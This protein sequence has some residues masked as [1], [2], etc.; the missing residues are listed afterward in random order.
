MNPRHVLKG[1]SGP[2][3]RGLLAAAVLGLSAL[4]TGQV[5]T[6]VL[7]QSIAGAAPGEPTMTMEVGGRTWA[8]TRFVVSTITMSNQPVLSMTGLLDGPKISKLGFLV[9]L[10]SSGDYIHS[11]ELKPMQ[12][13]MK[14]KDTPSPSVGSFNVDLLGSNSLESLFSF[15]SGAIV[16]Q[17]YDAAAKS[18]SGSF[19]GIMMSESG[20]TLEAKNGV[21][22]NVPI[23]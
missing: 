13:G 22:A 15:K 3:R 4:A 2:A 12:F 23:E 8:A 6:L 21:F 7:A 17:R 19:S 16:I 1:M 11:F 10:P 20:T 14:A 18:I 9:F 5:P